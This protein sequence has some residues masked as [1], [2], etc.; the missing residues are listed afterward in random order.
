MSNRFLLPTKGIFLKLQAAG[1]FLLSTSILT[2]LGSTPPASAAT[3][4][5]SFG[6]QV[7]IAAEC[8]VQ[9][10]N[11]LD[12]GTRGIL[13]VNVDVSTN[14]SI[15]CTNL[16]NYD[17]G[18]DAGSTPGGT[19][20]TRLMASGANT[21]SYAMYSG[22]FGGTNWGNTVGTDTVAG[23]GNGAMQ[24]LTVYGRIPPQTTPA[25]ATYTDNVTITIT[26]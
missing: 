11:T 10:T 25:V 5:G 2:G 4:T 21:V 24:T 17:V 14:F 19:T 12:F 6:S 1:L 7:I 23:V 18:L 8:K 20:T 16:T 15:Q 22:S 3:A 13:D 26:Y 9:S